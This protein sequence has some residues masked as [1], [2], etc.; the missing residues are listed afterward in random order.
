MLNISYSPINENW[1][2]ICNGKVSKVYK[3]LAIE[4]TK[5]VLI[6]QKFKSNIIVEITF[7]NESEIEKLNEKLLNK[8]GATDTI[9]TS[10]LITIED[11]EL[12]L[13]SVILCLS[14]I[15]QR[16]QESN[17]NELYHFAHIVVHSILHILEYTHEEEEK[18]KS[19]EMKE[20]NIL[21]KLGVPSPYL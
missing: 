14:V 10:E 4:I 15:K 9:S 18:R 6:H 2:I 13:G 20:C 12:I 8:T 16:A 19:M 1:K 3:T 21:A 11:Q 7:K 17:K 5:R